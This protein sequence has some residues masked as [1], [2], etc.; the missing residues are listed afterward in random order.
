VTIRRLT[1]TVAAL[2]AAATAAAGIPRGMLT[3]L[4]GV[5]LAI[6]ALSPSAAPPVANS[7]TNACAARK[8]A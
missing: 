4:A 6:T 8:Q 5:A 2:P 3:L 1:S 7:P